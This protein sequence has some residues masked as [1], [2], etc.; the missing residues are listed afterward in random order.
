LLLLDTREYAEKLAAHGC[1]IAT[2]VQKVFGHPDSYSVVVRAVVAVSSVMPRANIAQ[3][4]AT[5]LRNGKLRLT[6]LGRQ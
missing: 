6:S 1:V 4:M 5:L 3:S 2:V